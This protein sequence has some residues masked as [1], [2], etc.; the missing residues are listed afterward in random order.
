MDDAIYSEMTS[1]FRDVVDD[2]VIVVTAG[3]VPATSMTVQCDGF[4]LPVA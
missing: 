4:A 3:G 1:I 2:D